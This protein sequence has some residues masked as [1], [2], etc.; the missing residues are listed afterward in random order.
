MPVNTDPR[1]LASLQRSRKRKSKSDQG[2]Q[3]D[4]EQF[5]SK[6]RT[7]IDGAWRATANWRETAL[8]CFNFVEGK[9]WEDKDVE[10]IKKESPTR[11]IMT[12]NDVLP[13]VRILSGI[14]RQAREDFKIL[15]RQGADTDSAQM[16]SELFRFVS[17]ANLWF[18]QRIRKSNDVN[19]AGK[20][21]VKVD[22]SYEKN[23]LGDVLM[24]RKS[25]FEVFEDPL[26]DEW[27]GSDRRWCA[28]GIW[29]TE[30]EAKEL[31][32][33]FEDQITFGE[34]LSSDT[35]RMPA[36]LLGDTLGDISQYIDK[37]TKRV[38]IFDY[39]YKK[40]EV[41]TVAVNYLD[42]ESYP[43]TDDWLAKIQQMPPEEQAKW[44]YIRRPATTVR[45][46]T[47]MNWILLQ[48]KESPLPFC[49][50]PITRYMGLQ[51][52]GDPFGIVKDL[53]DPARLKNKSVSQALNHLN[54]SANSGWMNHATRGA[55]SGML[56]KFG[57]APGVVVNYREIEPKEIQ[58]APLSTGHVTLVQFGADQ[59]KATSLVNA[60]L[61]GVQHSNA[62]SG[63][64]IQARQQGGL[65][66]NEDLFDNGLLGDKIVGGQVIECIKAIFPPERVQEIVENL[67]ARNAQGVSAM[68]I[69]H[70]QAQLPTIIE[71]MLRSDYDYVVD[72]ASAMSSIRQQDL[73]DLRDIAKQFTDAGAPVPLALI[74]E[75]INKMDIS[76]EA[77][78]E[79]IAEITMM[80]QGGMMPPGGPAAGGKPMV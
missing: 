71:T 18:Y 28:D 50:L 34:W 11:P 32:P 53:R 6:L 31:W 40:R 45:V 54:R 30:D 56:E 63:K 55:D 17:D 75:G 22:I 14:E 77:R 13:I 79:M 12:F 58:P 36:H 60:E 7:D 66:G 52:L 4:V 33:E 46:A 80:R 15:P 2:E 57:S 16:M 43:A 21:Y 5:V 24:R 10:Y 59:I 41:V 73:A 48:D 27:D 49:E 44:K 19:I 42:G 1:N 65:V 67:S 20:G 47:F 35:G 29:V 74:R 9:Q 39:W 25:P 69:Q 3:A 26:A 72:R 78:G 51:Y 23:V 64:A 76:E 62:V 38:R 8:D 68:M 37:Q 70:N 61:Q